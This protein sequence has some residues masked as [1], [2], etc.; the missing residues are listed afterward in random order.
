MHIGCPVRCPEA[1]LHTPALPLP[2]APSHSQPHPPH[3]CSDPRQHCGGRA[4]HGYCL[5]PGLWQPGQEGLEAVSCQPAERQAANAPLLP[6]SLRHAACTHTQTTYP[7]SI[8]VDSYLAAAAALL[9][10]CVKGPCCLLCFISCF[11]HCSPL[12]SPPACTTSP[13][14]CAPG[15]HCSIDMDSDR[16]HPPWY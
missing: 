13:P 12:A 1:A 16:V 4:V 10:P 14:K 3:P 2:Y 15:F 9:C 11:A 8:P 6:P 7:P 5:F